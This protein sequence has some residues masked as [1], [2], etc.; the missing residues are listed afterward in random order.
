M[1]LPLS[2]LDDFYGKGYFVLEGVFSEKE[3]KEMHFATKRLQHMALGLDGDVLKS[4]SKLVVQDGLLERVV[5]AGVVEPLLLHYGRDPRLTSVV[6]D[7]LESN[8]ANHLINQVHLKL[9]G[10]GFYRWHQD[11]THRG[12]GT[13]DWVD[14]NERGS[15]VQTVTAI[16][17][18]TLKNGPLMFIPASCKKGHLYLPYDKSK[19]TV[20]D[21]FDPTEAVPLLMKPGDVAF[22]GPYTIHGSEINHS[23]QPRRVFI[24]GYAFPGANKRIYPGEGSGELV[25]LV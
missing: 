2:Y 16:D 8:Y 12:Y 9:P 5:W 10:G 18:A 24:N 14:V 23:D 3:I 25:K 22:F 15:Y 13:D 11:S 7:L 6:A 17:E 21:K 19:Q 1:T 4:G 20:S